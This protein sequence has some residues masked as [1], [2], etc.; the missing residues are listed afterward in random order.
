MPI[1]TIYQQA[2]RT[3]IQGLRERR[4]LL[5]VTQ[6]ALSAHLG[7]P[8]QTVSAIEAGARR[9]DLLEFVKVS[10]A[11]G[12]SANDASALLKKTWAEVQVEPIAASKSSRASKR[13]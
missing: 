12:L 11:L 6:T 13:T 5:G 4:E 8:Q 3:V 7:W 1:K 10:S 9:L 2:Y